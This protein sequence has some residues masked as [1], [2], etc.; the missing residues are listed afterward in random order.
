MDETD[1]ASARIAEL[2]KLIVRHQ[3]LYYNSRPELTDAEFDALWD[4]LTALSPRNPV[5]ARVGADASDGFA[6]ARHV[7]PMGS[8]AKAA[9]PEEFLAWCAKVRLPE[10]I[11]ELKLDGASLELQYEKGSLARA[12]TRGDGVMGDD[13]TQNARRMAGVPALLP[14]AWS[15]AV[16]GEVVMSRATHRDWFADKANCRNAANGLMKRKDGVGVERLEV[17][18]YDAAPRGLYDSGSGSLFAIKPEPPF[19]DELAKLA[20]LRAAG[21]AVTEAERFSEP[22]EVVDFRARV[23][24]GR[25][26]LAYDIDGLVVKARVVDIDDMKRDRPERQIAF[27]FPLEEATTTLVSIEWSESGATYTPVAIIEPV[28][29]AGTTVKRASL[30]NTNTLR[31]MGLRLGSRVVVVK[32]GE[33][34]PKIEGLVDNPPG[35]RPIDIPAACACGAALVDDGTRLYCPN[36]A[37]PKKALHRLEKWLA[38]LDVM[39]FGVTILRRLF[40]SGRVR[41]VADLYTLGAEEL[42]GYE[43]MGEASAAK[44]VQNLRARAEPTLAEFVAGFDIEGIGLLTVEKA[45]ARGFDT[46][47]KLRAATP[48]ELAAIDGFGDILAATLSEGL[49]ALGPEMDA[50]LA[51]GVVKIKPPEAGGGPLSGLS[52]CFTGEL[53]TMKRSR[54]E[55]LVKSLGGS[56]RNSVAKGLSYLVTNDPASGTGKSKKAASLGVAVIDEHA[57]LAL[58]ADAGKSVP[59][60]ELFG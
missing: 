52:F 4:E 58:V 25:A 37:C 53:N 17:I 18:C 9:D 11:V 5:L 60:G 40:D 15:G 2:E 8:Q 14:E 46:I 55:A 34:I 7:L 45:A 51:S 48:E 19:D 24:D 54:A 22:F 10:Y 56:A 28:R 21:F 41:T 36:S 31:G 20:W 44:I 26:A 6:K 13:I 42:A 59:P 12:V 33:I 32:R 30:A 29:L 27:K 23:M 38:A 39:E 47:E 57:F 3:D 16:R 50:V 49:K 43:R 35:S 1:A